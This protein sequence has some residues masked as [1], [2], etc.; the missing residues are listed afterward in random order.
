[1]FLKTI[2]CFQNWKL[3]QKIVLSF[4]LHPKLRLNHPSGIH[5]VLSWEI[6]A[7]PLWGKCEVATHTPGESSGI[8]ENSE[9]DCKGQNTLHWS[10]LYIVGKVS[11][12]KCLKCLTWAIWTFTTQVMVERRAGNQIGNLTPDH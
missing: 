6:V 7:T 2:M 8:L 1:M 3:C 11:K 10:V 12:C 4:K 9:L 5:D